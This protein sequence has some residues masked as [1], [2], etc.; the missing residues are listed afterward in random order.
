[1]SLCVV[2]TQC[3]AYFQVREAGLPLYRA[4]QTRHYKSVD[5]H[6]HSW[7]QR[8]GGGGGGYLVLAYIK[9]KTLCISSSLA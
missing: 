1:M 9:F 6:C 4:L 5:C 8:C 3:E 7:L 2:L